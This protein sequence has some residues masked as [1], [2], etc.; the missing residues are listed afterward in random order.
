[1]VQ[2]N[3][4]HVLNNSFTLVTSHCFLCTEEV[5]PNKRKQLSLKEKTELK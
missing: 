1:M 4:L 3:Y 2:P 5:V